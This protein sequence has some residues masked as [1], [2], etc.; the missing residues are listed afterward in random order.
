MDIQRHVAHAPRTVELGR[1]VATLN[2]PCVGC[3]DCRGLCQTLIELMTLP[4]V[5]LGRDAA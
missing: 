1:G 5:L 3:T 2:Q 4:D